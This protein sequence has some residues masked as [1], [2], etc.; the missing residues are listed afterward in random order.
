MMRVWCCYLFCIFFCQAYSQTAVEKVKFSKLDPAANLSNSRV[1]SILQDS[2]GFLWVGTEDGLNRFDGYEFKVYRNDP[3]DSTSLSKNSILQIYED[4]RGVLWISTANGGVHRYNS[5]LD[6]FTRFPEYSFD[7]EIR[8]FYEDR[9]YIWVAGVRSYHAFVDKLSKTSGKTLERHTLFPS[10]APVQFLMRASEDSFWVGVRTVGFFKW[11]VK[12]NAIVQYSSNPQNPDSLISDHV[13]KAVSDDNGNIWIGTEQGL[14]KFSTTKETFTNYTLTVP[15][16]EMKPLANNIMNLCIDKDYLWLGTEN[17]GLFRFNT[18]N[19]QYENFTFNKYDPASLPDNSVWAIYKDHEGRVWIGTY[20]KG[21]CVIDRLKEKFQ[22]VDIP[23]ENDIVNAIWQDS[24]KRFWIGTEDGIV[25]KR[26]NEIQHYKHSSKKGS[27]AT[28]PVLAIYEDD[29]QRMWF[30]TWNGGLNRYD[31]KTNSFINYLPDPEKNNSLSNADVFAITQIRKTGAIVAGTYS[32][33]SILADEKKGIFERYSEPLF[34]FNNYVRIMREDSKGNLWIGTIEELTLFDSNQKKIIRF[35]SL[36]DRDSIKVDGLSNC[37][38]EDKKGRIWVGTNNGLHLIIG[39]KHIRTYTTLDGLP[40]NIVSGILE[41]RKGRLWLSTTNGI[42]R[43]DPDKQTFKNYDVNDGLLSNEF[44]PNAC[45]KNNEGQFF[46]GGKG[47][48]V[49]YPDSIKDNP[50]VPPVFIT[51]LKLLNKSVKAGDKDGIL[52][53]QISKTLEISLPPDYNFFTINYVA[54]NFTASNKNQYA[55]KLE[56][57]NNEWN[58][59]GNQRAVTFTNLD[60]GDY[61]FRVKASNN[62]GLWNEEGALLI[63][64]ILPPWWKTWW[65]RSLICVLIVLLAVVIYK[66]RLGAVTRQNRKLEDLVDERT[67]ELA[68]QNEELLQSQEEI[69]SQRDLVSAQNHE[70]QFA[71]EII[72]KQ[73]NEIKLRNETLEAEVEERTRDLVEYNQQLEQFAFISAHNLRAPV[74]RILGLG[75]VLE[76]ARHKPD[77]VNMIIDRIIFTTQELDRVVK[78]LNTV[79][80]LRKNNTSVITKINLEEE[81]ELI[82]INLEKEIQ[83]THTIFDQDFSKIN[84]IH[85]LKPYLD[86]IL[87]NLISN[88]IK[89]RQPSRPPIIRIHSFIEGDL[90]C[91]EVRDNGLGM[92]LSLYKEKIFTLYSRFH[93]HVEGKGMGLYLVKTQAHSLGGRIEV[94]SETGIGTTFKVYIRNQVPS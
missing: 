16:N 7:C 65:F 38:T 55:Y 22:E 31:D 80:E 94:E 40:N 91:L 35:E 6:N 89:Y 72:E 56:G 90:V 51:D 5:D 49:F 48:N 36:N 15:K 86:S 17:G 54:L 32:G 33:V 29:R 85:T 9:D 84:I 47:I 21:I 30:G 18:M 73:N 10:K 70:L 68:L 39:R 81:L 23:L 87:V 44:K 59:V 3:S 77:D 4:K 25:M 79:L 83:E 34:Q 63:I 52:T 71:R 61:I 67:R 14:S 41:D 45:F 13:H 12:T 42:S 1:T 93:S 75:N 11:N 62:D 69:S 19:G 58:Y 76:I 28:N 60:P 43:F 27:L 26:G 50:H 82:K 88:A 24:K 66:V 92:D 2:D 46:F 64:H 74:A 8:S 20:S 53:E 78:D 57:F 37:I